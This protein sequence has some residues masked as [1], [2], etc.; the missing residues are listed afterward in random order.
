MNKVFLSHSSHD[1]L[2]VEYIAT[3]FGKDIAIYDSFSFE[4]GLKTLD[5]ILNNLDSTDIFVIFLSNAALE[6]EWV[7]KELSVSNELKQKDKIKQIYPIIIDSNLSHGDPRIPKWL[8]NGFDSYNLR[9]ISSPKMAYRKIKNQLIILNNQSHFNHYKVYIGHEDILKKFDDE[10]YIA[11]NSP[12]CIIACGIEGV[13]REA[14]IREC[15]KVPKTFS[16]FYE[17]IV[18]STD[19]NDSI[20]AIISK[21]IESG[22]GDVDLLS[23][24]K[25]NKLAIDE[26]INLLSTILTQIQNSKEFVIF[27]DNGALIQQQE[28]IWWLAKSLEPIRNELTIGIAS[29]YNVRKS[30][31]SKDCYIENINELDESGKLKLLDKLAKVHGLTLDRDDIKFF[32]NIVTG[33]PLQIIFCIEKIKRE[34]LEEVKSNSFEITEFLS[35]STIKIIDKYLALLNY[36]RD[37][38]E[39]FLSYLAFLAS[40]SNIPIAE[41]LEIN[42]LDNDY[43][44]FYFDLLSFCIARRT[45][46]NNDLLSV[47]P[48]VVDYIERSSDIKKPDDINAYLKNEYDTFK[49]CLKDNNLDEYCYSQIEQN[50]KELIINSEQAD[51]KYIYPSIILKAVIQL[52]N[53]QGYDKIINICANCLDKLNFWESTIRQTLYFYYAMAVAR[54]KDKNIFEILYKQIDDQYILEKFQADFI[55]GFYYKL[56]GRYEEATT[57]FISCL[58]TKPNYARACRE[59]VETYIMLDE[60][61]LA[62]DLAARNYSKFPN[63][64][65]NIYQYFNCLIRNKVINKEKIQELLDKAREVDRL[66]T[67]SKKFFANM[68]SLYERFVTH[69]YEKA[70]R[71]LYDNKKAFDNQIYYYR[72]I[73]DLYVETKNIK[74]MEEAVDNLKKA[75]GKDNAFFPL[76]FRRECILLYFQTKDFALVNNKII[77]SNLISLKTKNKIKDYIMSLK[78]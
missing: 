62:L 57:Q 69:D 68:K 39:K 19:S 66:P 51:Y 9:Y 38:K 61:E 70:I 46:L 53:K 4:S 72:D 22:F 75:V 59:L 52:Y 35:D 74:A 50:L 54:K 58:E 27:R 41:V 56:L 15:V 7:K 20:D 11:Q 1:K 37:K 47:S 36:D 8:N 73:F 67:S 76:L 42:K 21:L 64:I 48:S 65:F 60:F 40:Y 33:H 78:L 13:G 71:I 31:T 23:I 28:V 63:N 12:K 45:G 6:S 55:R 14:F 49:T 3:K 26:K 44:T 10:Y 5:E 24:E 77:T 18:I 16:D 29:Y 2:Y 25:L 34:S 17:P 30:K 43:K 32:Q